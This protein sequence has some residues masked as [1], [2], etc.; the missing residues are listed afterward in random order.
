[1]GMKEALGFG[2]EIGFAGA[3]RQR[4]SSFLQRLHSG[5]LSSHLTLRALNTLDYD[6][7]FTLRSTYL[8]TKQ[9]VL[10]FG[11]PARRFFPD[12]SIRY[13]LLLEEAFP[14][15]YSHNLTALTSPVGKI[16]KIK[17]R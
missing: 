5:L 10:T 7:A 9:P 13:D 3:N 8:Q 17:K 11:F 1:M 15:E 16:C 2:T 4:M 14:E 6:R 12:W